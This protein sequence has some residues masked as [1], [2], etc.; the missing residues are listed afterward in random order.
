MK[1][2]PVCLFCYNRD[3]ELKKTVKA[4]SQN[5]NFKNTDLYVFCDGPKDK[6]DKN[7][8]DSVR[9]IVKNIK[10]A[11]N[12]YRKY[13]KVNK[14]LASSII[15]GVSK[16]YEKYD[17]VI[18]I[19]DD[20]ITS[21]DFLNFMNEGLNNYKNENKIF[22]IN[23]YSHDLKSLSN[24]SFDNYFLNRPS[25]WGWATW[26]DR[27]EKINWSYE[28]YKK[29]NIFQY[30]FMLKG[31]SDLPFMLNNY[32]KNKIN[33]WA[34]RFAYT[35]MSLNKL[36]VVST[37]SKIKNIGFSED[38]TN[39]KKKS[40]KSNFKNSEKTNFNFNYKIKVNNSINKE[41]LNV[42]SISKRLK[43]LLKR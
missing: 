17:S 43:N 16:V 8:T 15:E 13:S 10:G 26:K 30:L 28:F 25:S 6:L 39:T 37:I 4:L 3:Y 33:S 32:K 21:N 14:G 38:A 1:Y 18:V 41:F 20:L 24:Y 5:I 9:K 23:G 34:I 36:S 31:G 27:W 22:S 29:L 42:Y 12:I 2:S 7:K 40:I 11:K 35:Q 19:E